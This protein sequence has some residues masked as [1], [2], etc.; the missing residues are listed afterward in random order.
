MDNNEKYAQSNIVKN[1][2]N[3][4]TRELLVNMFALYHIAENYKSIYKKDPTCMIEKNILILYKHLV[5]PNYDGMMYSFKDKYICNEALVEKNNTK[6]QVQGLRSVYDYIESYDT[7]SHKNNF[8]IFIESMNI[9]SK[10]WKYVDDKNNEEIYKEIDELKQKE[11]SLMKEANDLKNN[12]DYRGYLEKKREAEKIEKSISGVK[13]GS[14]IGGQIRNVDVKLNGYDIEVPNHN[15]VLTLMNEYL[16]PEKQREFKDHLDNDD[17]IDYI[18]YVVTET[19][20]LI[21]MQ[22]FEDGNKR[23]FRSLL[24]LM[25]KLRGLPPVYIRANERDEYKDALY[26]AMKD[27][28][29]SEIKGFYL[30]KLCDSIYELDIEPYLEK[31]K[32]S[33]LKDNNYGEFGDKTADSCNP[34]TTRK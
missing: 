10:L 23:T 25:F 34:E 21:K 20:K 14:K 9:N 29:Y 5:D 4:N 2:I 11:D 31:R 3:D 7:E 6:E 26:K 19:V 33:E 27:N 12:K 22:P 18:G 8:N 13:E 32:A 30:F 24:N 1:D 28:N 17:I 15:E 16:D